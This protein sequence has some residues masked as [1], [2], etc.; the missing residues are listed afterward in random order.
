MVGI[1]VFQVVGVG[2]N[3]PPS[4]RRI[5]ELERC[6]ATMGLKRTHPLMVCSEE[7]WAMRDSV[8]QS[9]ANSWTALRLKRICFATRSIDA[10][11][12]QQV[13]RKC[14][15][16]VAGIHAGRAPFH[17]GVERTNVGFSQ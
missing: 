6:T 3:S 5:A 7:Y 2:V 12:Q 1:V 16:A 15:P 17:Y 14:V 4:Q 8:T 13:L 10:K 9:I 11:L